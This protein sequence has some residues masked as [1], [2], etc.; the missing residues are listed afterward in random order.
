MRAAPRS[1][2]SPSSPRVVHPALLAVQPDD[3]RCLAMLS[4]RSR[5]SIIFL[6]VG[7]GL[8]EV[9][10][11]GADLVGVGV[12]ELVEDGQGLPPG[13]AGSSGVTGVV[14]GVEALDAV[15][16]ARRWL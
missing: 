9:G 1:G 14:V 5:R 11:L 4:L 2:Y 7:R 13:I 8:V 15:T 12:V 6:T 3:L 16:Q 10:E